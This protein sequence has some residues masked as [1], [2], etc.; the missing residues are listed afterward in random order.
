MGSASGERRRHQALEVQHSATS[1]AI[2]LWLVDT[3][4]APGGGGGTVGGWVCLV[5][6]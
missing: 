1:T 4:P 6:S 2:A 3:L 5:V